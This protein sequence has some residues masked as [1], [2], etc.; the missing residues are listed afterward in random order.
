MASQAPP[1]GKRLSF[2]G[3]QLALAIDLPAAI[4][5]GALVGGFFGYLL[6]RWW[7]TKPILMITL[8]AL[9]FLGGVFDAL[10]RLQKDGSDTASDARR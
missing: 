6:D 3:R 5:G 1:P 7:H 8:G 2:L 10:R 4:V 9:G